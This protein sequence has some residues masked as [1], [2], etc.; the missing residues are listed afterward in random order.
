MLA[1]QNAIRE[2]HSGLK[3]GRIEIGNH[4]LTKIDRGRGLATGSIGKLDRVTKAG[5]GLPT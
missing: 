5:E 1:S 4:K 2:L 3:Y